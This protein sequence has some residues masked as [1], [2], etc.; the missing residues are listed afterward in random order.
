MKRRFLTIFSFGKRANPVLMS[1]IALLFFSPL[2]SSLAFAESGMPAAYSLTASSNGQGRI[3]PSGA[4][5]V[6]EGE[7]ASFVF[8]A[9]TDCHIADIIVD[10]TSVGPIHALSFENITASHTVQAVFEVDSNSMNASTDEND[11]IVAG[12][13]TIAELR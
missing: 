13:Q 5:T 7:S 4:I 6:R 9:E 12:N 1:A 3:F 2:V 11:A 10:G 8:N